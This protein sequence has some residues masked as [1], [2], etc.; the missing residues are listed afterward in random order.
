MSTD[1]DQMEKFRNT[2]VGVG[3]SRGSGTG[4]T[5]RAVFGGNTY[6]LPFEAHSKCSLVIAEW[7]VAYVIE[8][9]TTEK[10]YETYESRKL[11]ESMLVASQE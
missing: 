5:Q 3:D 1:N 4:H 2:G 11:D 6:L 7:L 8:Y 9:R 10:S